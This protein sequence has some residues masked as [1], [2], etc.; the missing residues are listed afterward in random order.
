MKTWSRTLPRSYPISYPI[1]RLGF[2]QIQKSWTSTVEIL[3][4]LIPYHE[5]K[6]LV[7]GQ[8]EIIFQHAWLSWKN[9]K[10]FPVQTFEVP[11]SDEQIHLSLLVH[12][13]AESRLGFRTNTS[14]KVQFEIKIKPLLTSGFLALLHFR[15]WILTAW[16]QPCWRNIY[17]A[18]DISTF[19]IAPFGH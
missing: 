15:K 11:N 18:S 6:R 2:K 13:R 12:P 3:F 19:Y 4:S 17:K 1:Y 5:I 7:V 9:K 16:W 10:L 8:R 14:C